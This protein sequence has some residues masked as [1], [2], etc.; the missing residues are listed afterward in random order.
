ML[1]SLPI[2]KS[3][4]HE[5]MKKHVLTDPPRADPGPQCFKYITIQMGSTTIG[6]V[7]ILGELTIRCVF[8]ANKHSDECPTCDYGSLDLSPG[9]FTHFADFDAGTI[10]ITWWFDDDVS[11]AVLTNFPANLLLTHHCRVLHR[12]PL[13]KPRL[14]LTYLPLPPGLRLHHHRRPP[15]SG[16]LLRH[17][18]PLN[19]SSLLPHPLLLQPANGILRPPKPLLRPHLPP[20]G[21]L[22]PPLLRQAWLRAPPALHLTAL[23]RPATLP[24]LR[25]STL[26]TLTPLLATLPTAVFLLP[27][28]PIRVSATGLHQRLLMWATLR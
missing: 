27:F 1:E 8:F 23:S 12:L 25:P 28:P 11:W 2:K 10:H 9:L 22:P 26:P 13:L 21:W 17:H 20:P 5:K 19:G 15:T 7:E 6:G 16:F 4:L 24:P 3:K 18:P 14:P